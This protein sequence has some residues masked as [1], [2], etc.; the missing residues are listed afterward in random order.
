[1]T[2]N[3]ATTTT[4]T[5]AVAEPGAAVAPEKAPRKK[6][7]SQKRGA[8][9]GHKTAKAAKPASKPKAGKTGRQSKAAG[10]EPIPREGTAKAK[11]IAMLERKGGVTMDEIRKVTGWQP[12]SV[13]GFI[14]ILKSKHGLK[15]ESSRRESDKARVYE[16]K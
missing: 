7:A 2:N 4:Q 13:R 8:P 15:V 16:A 12:H 10:E 1:M 11:V 9:K 3:E 14:S 5:A 6:G